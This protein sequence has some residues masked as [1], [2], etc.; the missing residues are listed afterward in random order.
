[1]GWDTIRENDD[2]KFLKIKAGSQNR[3][4]IIGEEPEYHVQHFVGKAP[5]KCTGKSCP[6]CAD[7]NEKRE[8]WSI[9]IFNLDTMKSQTLDAGKSVFGKTKKIMKMY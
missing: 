4:H 5:Q 8:T 2:T 1:M 9:L 7:G 6:L 3:V